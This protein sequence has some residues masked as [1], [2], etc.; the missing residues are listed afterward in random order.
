MWKVGTSASTNTYTQPM[1]RMDSDISYQM[2]PQW[3]LFFQARN[4]TNTRL[5]FTQSSNSQFPLQREYYGQSF[6]FGV[7]YHM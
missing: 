3:Q 7:H 2:T 1:F 4:L 5:E 6:L